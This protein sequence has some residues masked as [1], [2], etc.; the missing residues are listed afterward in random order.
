MPKAKK[1]LGDYWTSSIHIWKGIG[2]R[3]GKPGSLRDV[4]PGAHVFIAEGIED[5][6]SAVVL[7]PEARVLAAISLSNLGHVVLPEAVSNVTLIA[8]LD[9]NKT[10]R[11]ELDRAIASH[12]AAGR[13]VRVFQNRW[14]GKD[15]NDALR[16]A[17][18]E[19][20]NGRGAA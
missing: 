10:A 14:G 1:V 16:A 5:A 19:T 9:D 4:K 20:E 18:T 17:S 11:D 13:T 3:G 12:Q 6:L 8:D 15:L 7:K 2:P